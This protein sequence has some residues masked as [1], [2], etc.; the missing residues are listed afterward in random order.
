[1]TD[2]VFLINSLPR[3]TSPTIH[4]IPLLK[5]RGSGIRWLYT[6]GLP[7]TFGTFFPLVGP[8]LLDFTDSCRHVTPVL[9]SPNLVIIL[10][11]FSPVCCQFPRVG[12]G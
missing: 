8:L 11:D 1:M 9:L 5:P 6:V 4:L 2:Y 12:V 10:P 7:M 3:L